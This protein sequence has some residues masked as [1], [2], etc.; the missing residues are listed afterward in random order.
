MWV[1]G[2]RKSQVI[3]ADITSDQFGGPPVLV[4]SGT[5]PTHTANQTAKLL[6]RFEANENFH[7]SLWVATLAFALPP[8]LIDRSPV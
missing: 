5:P 7:V 3:T 2:R 1:Q 8:P 6:N 4:C